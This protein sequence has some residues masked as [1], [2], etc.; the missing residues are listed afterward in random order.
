MLYK[1][2]K[3]GFVVFLG[4]FSPT[5]SKQKIAAD[6]PLRAVSAAMV[7]MGADRWNVALVERLQAYKRS[8]CVILSYFRLFF[9]QGLSRSQS[10]AMI[11]P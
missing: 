10:P 4:V 7:C 1:G 11:Q 5:I 8:V 2:Y 3:V 9:A 6:R